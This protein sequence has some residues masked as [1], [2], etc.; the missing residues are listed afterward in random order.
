MDF[1]SKKE[2]VTISFE[3]KSKE[4]SLKFGENMLFAYKEDKENTVAQIQNEMTDVKLLKKLISDN[5]K[6]TS[7][8]KFPNDNGRKIL[9]NII[10]L[11]KGK[12]LFFELHL[13]DL[14]E[15]IMNMDNTDKTAANEVYLLYY[16]SNYIASDGK[17]VGQFGPILL[18]VPLVKGIID[19]PVYLMID[20]EMNEL[21]EDKEYILS[22]TIQEI[23]SVLSSDFD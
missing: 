19:E 1:K 11:P 12:E 2:N 9:L 14:F 21:H 17:N 5:L 7:K 16:S 4:E 23:I 13:K 20:G 18:I 22:G 3:R 8:I 6:K 10:D 15:E